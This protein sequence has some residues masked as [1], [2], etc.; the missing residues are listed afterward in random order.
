M[1]CSLIKE[2]AFW[3]HALLSF[4]FSFKLFSWLSFLLF[5]LLSYFTFYFF[6]LF[7]FFLHFSCSAKNYDFFWPQTYNLGTGNGVSVLEL[8][9]AFE[10]VTSTKVAYEL[11]PRREGDIVSMFA[12]TSLARKE[13]LWE[14]KYSLDNMCEFYSFQTPIL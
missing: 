8:I 5:T 2:L 10:K 4:Y 3:I 14:S 7:L 11:K 6:L 9:A 12:D 1:N 13:L